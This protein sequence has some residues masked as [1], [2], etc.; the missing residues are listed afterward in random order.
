VTTTRTR[1]AESAKPSKL[2][3]TAFAVSE[4][5]APAHLVILLGFVVAWHA[6]SDPAR[7]LGWGLLTVLFTGVIPYAFV[8]LG[9]RRGKWVNHHIPDRQHRPAAL[10]FG[11]GSIVAGLAAVVAL[12]APRDLVALVVAQMVGLSVALVITLAWK[13]S[14]HVAVAF[15]SVA[16]L[17]I[18]FGPWLYLTALAAVAVAWSRVALNAHTLAQVLGGGAIGATIAGSVFTALTR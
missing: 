3:R 16:I 10:L 14:I 17:V 12:G 5:L 15:G 1:R 11:V 9:V 2:G 7:G 4:V 6:A 13:V 8:L 18:V